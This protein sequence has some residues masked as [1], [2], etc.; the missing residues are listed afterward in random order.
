MTMTLQ[1]TPDI[2][3]ELGDLRMRLGGSH[4][5]LVGFAAET[6]DVVAK[7]RAKRIRKGVD[8]IVANDVSRADR[9]FES[10]QNAVTIVGTD[11][12]VDVPLQSK[13]DVAAAILDRIET[14][15][16][17]QPPIPTQA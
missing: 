5:L 6:D 7:A 17:R 12:E 8:L 9:G 1:R 14:L 2:L 15:L 16:V 13:A 10:A 3:A 11:D 4:P